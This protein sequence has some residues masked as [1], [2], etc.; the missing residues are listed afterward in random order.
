MARSP[1]QENTARRAQ[2]LDADYVPQ[3]QAP[4]LP[5]AGDGPRERE[6]ASAVFVIMVCVALL[7][8]GV[9][10]TRGDGGADRGADP[11]VMTV[12]AGGVRTAPR[13]ESFPAPRED[14]PGLG[15]A[16]QTL[17]A[18]VA[19]Y[20][21]MKDCPLTP[22]AQVY[23]LEPGGP[24]EAAGLRPG[25]VITA[26]DGQSVL[27]AEDLDAALSGAEAGRTVT[28][29]VFRGGETLELSAELAFCPGGDEDGFFHSLD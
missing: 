26:V 14:G 11:P 27:T 23:A 19:A 6:G 22:G 3:D 29:A 12:A 5:R 28:L 20:Y 21:S 13:S 10:V 15:L 9:A 25:D 7:A 24:A 8:L 18:P 17:S 1:S 2:I 16:V 4:N